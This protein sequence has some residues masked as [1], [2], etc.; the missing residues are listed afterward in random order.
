MIPR[1]PG[2]V[3]TRLTRKIQSER[4]ASDLTSTCAVAKNSRAISKSGVQSCKD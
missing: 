1:L 4:H 3:Q 2:D